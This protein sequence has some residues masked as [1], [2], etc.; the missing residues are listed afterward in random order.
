MNKFAEI[1]YGKVANL[2]DTTRT[3]DEFRKL[4]TPS[5]LII[6]VTAVEDVGVGYRVD[7][8]SET[9]FNIIPPK[10]IIPPTEEEQLQMEALNTK[11]ALQNKVSS[12]MLAVLAGSSLSVAQAEYKTEIDAIEDNVAM[13]IPEVFPAWSA[14]AVQY[15]VGQRVQ[16]NGVLYKVLTAHTSQAAWTPTDA[17]SL[18]VKVISSIN[19]EIPDWE[20]PSA[21]NA[22]MKG[23]R[24]RFEG[25]VYESL[26]DNNV[27]S[28]T[29]YPDGWKDVTDEV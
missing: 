29:D 3:I 4:F 2:Y 15:E 6:D 14:D 22:Y 26:I 18:F 27:W 19:G 1:M 8:T 25:R 12:M 16:Y 11:S 9:N 13:Y 23:D 7:F 5:A 24:V 20:Q 28:P 17:P 10:K 21:N